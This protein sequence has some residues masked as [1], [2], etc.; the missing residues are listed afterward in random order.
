MKTKEEL[1]ALKAEY[2]A[3]NKKLSEL[4]EAELL[5]V[6]GGVEGFDIRKDEY[7]NII[8]SSASD[9]A[10]IRTGDTRGQLSEEQLTP[11]YIHR[12]IFGKKYDE[13]FGD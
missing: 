11:A 2:N 13:F 6:C 1:T 3:L 10:K 9:S 5:Q 8:L 12:Q 4:T 7:E